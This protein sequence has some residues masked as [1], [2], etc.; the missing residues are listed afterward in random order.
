MSISEELASWSSPPYIVPA[1]A[2]RV[3]D[4]APSDPE[5]VLPADDGKPTI[6]AFLRHCG[7]PGKLSPLLQS[8]HIKSE[9]TLIFHLPAVAEATFLAMRTAAIKHPDIN[10]IAISHSDQ[11]STEKWLNAVGGPGSVRVI[12]DAEREIYA[13]WGLGVVP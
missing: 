3:G 6:I 13:K 1:T 7:C 8:F 10:F 9:L 2:P 5:L 4:K 11:P 12:V